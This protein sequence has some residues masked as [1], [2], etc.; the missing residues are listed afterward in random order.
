MLRVSVRENRKVRIA[1]SDGGG[2]TSERVAWPL[3]LFFYSHVAL[4]GAWCELRSDYRFFCSGRI[5]RLNSTVDRFN[6]RSGQLLAEVLA[7]FHGSQGGYTTSTK[8][9]I[10]V[11]WTNTRE[12]RDWHEARC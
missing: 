1:Y 11:G 9:I 4:L 12:G 3:T 8:Q 6:T 2:R 7:R 5:T 10:D